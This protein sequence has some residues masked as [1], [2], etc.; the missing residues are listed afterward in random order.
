MHELEPD[1]YYGA[2]YIS[3]GFSMDILRVVV[4][5]LFYLVHDPSLWVYATTVAVAV[6]SVTPLLFRYSRTVML[7]AFGGARFDRCYAT[8]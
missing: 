1:F 2:M 6:M 5:L 7:Y 8:R 3:S 4:S